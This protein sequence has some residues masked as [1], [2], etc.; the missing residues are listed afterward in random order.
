MFILTVSVYLVR[1]FTLF[2]V[3][4]EYAL[5]I[6]VAVAAVYGNAMYFIFYMYMRK[7]YAARQIDCI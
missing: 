5:S 2:I 1:I 6:S 4:N 3:N 7:K